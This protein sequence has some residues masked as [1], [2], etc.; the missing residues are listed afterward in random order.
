[1]PDP[2][3]DSNEQPLVPDMH[4]HMKGVLRLP[5]DEE[6]QHDDGHL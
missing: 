5:I 4:L 2:L 6:R 3:H 1:M